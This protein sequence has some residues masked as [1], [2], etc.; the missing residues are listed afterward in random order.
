MIETGTRVTDYAASPATARSRERSVF[1]AEN[2]RRAR[3]LRMAGRGA[4]ALTLIWL[5]A[6]L[7]AVLPFGDL[8][9]LSGRAWVAHDDASRAVDRQNPIM[10]STALIP[11]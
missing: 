11:Q 6:L 5:A 3:R 7:I 8:P 9:D 10:R 4:A 2:G 1:V